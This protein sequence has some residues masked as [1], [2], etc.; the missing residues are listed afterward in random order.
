M[1]IFIGMFICVCVYA[2][3]EIITCASVYFKRLA[4]KQPSDLFLLLP[5]YLAFEPVLS[6]GIKAITP[7]LYLNQDALYKATVFCFFTFDH[8]VLTHI[9]EA[10]SR[11]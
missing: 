8:W 7:N 1:C 9:S 4:T 3:T 2:Y 10:Y 5:R 11:S 6:Y